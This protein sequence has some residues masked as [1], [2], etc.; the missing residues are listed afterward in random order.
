MIANCSVVALASRTDAAPRVL[1]EAMAAGK[2]MV[3]SRV[4]GIPYYVQDGVNELL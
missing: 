2:P 4:G 3:A 1:F